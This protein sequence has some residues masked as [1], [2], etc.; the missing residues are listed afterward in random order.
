MIVKTDNMLRYNTFLFFLVLAGSV[1]AQSFPAPSNPPRLVND[2][3]GVLDENTRNQMEQT[4]VQFSNETST[5]IAV[6]ILDDLSGYDVSDYTFR[7]AESWGI[8]QK[9][10]NNGILVL[11]KPK[12]GREKGEAFIAVGYGLEGVVPDAV[13]RRIVNNEMIPRFRENDYTGGLQAGLGVLMQITRGEFT[14]EKYLANTGGSPAK[15]GIIFLLLIVGVVFILI[16]GQRA[17]S[18]AIGHSLPFWVMLS[19]L[20]SGSSHSGRWDNFSSGSGGFG[21]G[22]GGFGGFGGGSFGGGGAGGSW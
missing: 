11:I 5:Q 14:G 13:A 15:G 12:S 7:L 9:G 10:K 3:T 19:M 22:G 17:Q 18:S 2:L 20:G 1:F 4:L 6:A 21:G 16:K 8:G